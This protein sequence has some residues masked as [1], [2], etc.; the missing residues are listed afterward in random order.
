M[1][2]QKSIAD[3]ARPIFESLKSQLE[4]DHLTLSRGDCTRFLA[5]ALQLATIER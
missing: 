5:S 3:A 2:K 1:E 4:A